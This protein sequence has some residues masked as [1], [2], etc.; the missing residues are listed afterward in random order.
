VA[1]EVREILSHHVP[2]GLE[3][4]H[5]RDRFIE[6]MR[7]DELDSMSTVEVVVEL[8]KHFGIDVPDSD[9]ESIRTVGELVDYIDRRLN[10]QGGAAHRAAQQA[11]AADEAQGGTRTAS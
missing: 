2:Y 4:L 3:G 6:D 10:A 11:D 9:A 1:A 7:M 5:P 8:E